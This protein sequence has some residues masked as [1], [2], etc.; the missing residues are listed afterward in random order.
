M[1]RIKLNELRQE[2][3]KYIGVPYHK[4]IP[5][6]I[7]LDNS[8][9]GKGNAK[10]I[11]LKTIELANKN[12][13]KI[14]DLSPKQ[15]YNFQKKNKIGIDCSGLACHLLNFYFNTK[16]DVRKTSSDMLTSVPLSKRI[17]INDI[18]TADL[19]RQ[20]NGHH[21]LFV[22]EK[23]GDKIIYVDSSLKGR[24]VRYGEFEITD[25]DFKHNGVF[26]LNLS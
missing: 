24:G 3:L 4:N 9:L 2:I 19:V 1:A 21:L 23:I 7:S 26:R 10:E 11:A 15:I 12:N 17:D 6:I 22:I 18:Q 13:L 25:K 5:K 8:L 20:K 16:L 14:L